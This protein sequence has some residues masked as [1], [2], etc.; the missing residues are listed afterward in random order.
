MCC[1]SCPS[2]CDWIL[3]AE[4]GQKAV[5]LKS[6]FVQTCLLV[7]SLELELSR[8]MASTRPVLVHNVIQSMRNRQ[9]NK[10]T[11]CVKF[12]GKG[13]TFFRL[14]YNERVRKMLTSLNSML[15]GRNKERNEDQYLDL[16]ELKRE[17]DINL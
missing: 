5:D 13:R 7:F 10:E 8:E 11:R 4:P 2:F 16:K 3:Y 15:H 1:L 6:N 17:K 12:K 14:K 9:D